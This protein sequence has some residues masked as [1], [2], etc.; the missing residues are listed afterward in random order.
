MQRRTELVMSSLVMGLTHSPGRASVAM[1]AV[2]LALATDAEAVVGRRV[3]EG[4][5]K[6]G[7][8][9]CAAWQAAGSVAESK[10]HESRTGRLVAAVDRQAFVAG[11]A[12]QQ[13]ASFHMG[14]WR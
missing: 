14:R 11:A 9:Q 2:S 6:L 7:R 1:A 4:R 3:A 12:R 10:V 8:E 13:L 5:G